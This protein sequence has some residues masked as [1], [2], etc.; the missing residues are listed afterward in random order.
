LGELT[1]EEEGAIAEADGEVG[2][3]RG[4]SCGRDGMG[5]VIVVELG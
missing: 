4:E 3:V 1:V 5:S 2:E